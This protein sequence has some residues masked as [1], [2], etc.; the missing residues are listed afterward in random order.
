V[1]SAPLP[2][3]HSTRF[4]STHREEYGGIEYGG[5]PVK[6]AVFIVMNRIV[7]EFFA[8]LRVCEQRF[9]SRFSGRE[10]SSSSLTTT[11]SFAPSDGTRCR[12]D[13][14]ARRPPPR[15]GPRPALLDAVDLALLHG[16]VPGVYRWR[17]D[18][19]ASAPA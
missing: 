7:E 13:A 12:L 3:S 9:G 10:S 14:S 1:K 5:L 2:W 17:F 16:C 19:T 11:S 6:Y 4:A 15:P 18:P 8:D